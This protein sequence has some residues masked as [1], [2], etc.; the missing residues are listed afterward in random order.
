MNEQKQS[1]R[2]K[3]PSFWITIS[4]LACLIGGLGAYIA[5]TYLFNPASKTTPVPWP[6]ASTQPSLSLRGPLSATIKQGQVLT[7]HGEHFRANAPISFLLDSTLSIKDKNNQNTSARASSRGDFDTSIP[8][9]GPDWSAKPH[10]IQGIDN[11]TRQSAYLSVVVSP[12]STPVTT[13]QNLALSIQGTSVQGLTF[14][15]VLGQ[16]Y[17]DQQRVTLTNTSGS[18]LH[19]TVTTN[20]DNNLAWLVV[21]DNHLAG[22]LDINGTDSIGISTLIRALKANSTYKG[23]I[24]FTINRQEQLLLPVELHMADTQSEI[25]FNPN[26]VAIV[27]AGN[28]CP[29]TTFTLINVGNAFINWTLSPSPAVKNHIRFTANGQSVTQG[30]LASSG[31]DGDTQLLKLECSGVSAGESYDFVM[32]AGPIQAPVTITIQ[33][34]S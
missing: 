8:I 2:N 24:V 33:A 20:A 34:S 21:D 27:G 10:Y 28:T 32:Y 6:S 22:N 12:A 23:Q 16:E 31:V 14:H 25:V 5:S 29:G 13:S 3:E 1:T 26:P 17:P 19:W 15:A 11:L 7:L 9:Q 4:V 18:P 30:Q